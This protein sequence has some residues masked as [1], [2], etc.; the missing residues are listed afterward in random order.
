MPSIRYLKINVKIEIYIIKYHFLYV[1]VI[2]YSKIIALK[3][4]YM[5]IY[6]VFDKRA[7]LSSEKCRAEKGLKLF[8]QRSANQL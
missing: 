3:E 2:Y 4:I 8:S 1:F 7:S 5:I 6:I